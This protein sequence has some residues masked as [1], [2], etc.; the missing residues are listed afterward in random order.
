MNTVTLFFILSSLPIIYPII[1]LFKLKDLNLWDFLLFFSCIFFSLI[2]A[3]YSNLGKFAPGIVVNVSYIIFIFHS[4]LLLIDFNF[5]KKHDKEFRILNICYFLRHIHQLRLSIHGKFLVA[6]GLAVIIV[7]YLPRMSIAVRMGESASKT[8]Y[9]ISSVAMALNSILSIIGVILTLA[10]LSNL[11]RFKKDK[12]LIILVIVYLGIMIFMPRRIMVFSLIQFAVVYYALYRKKIS[13]KIIS[14]VLVLFFGIYF[15]YFPFYNVIRTNNVSFNPRHPIESLTAIINYGVNNFSNR[16][17]EA[18]QSTDE[19]TLGLYQALYNLFNNC[20]NW[21]NGSLTIAAIDGAIPRV[22]NPNKGNGTE[23]ILENMS[24]SYTDQADSILLEAC[25][26]F[27]S[28]GALYAVVLFLILFW[29]YEKYSYLYFKLFK[30]YLVPTFIMFEMLSITWNIEGNLGG[31]IAFFFSSIFTILLLLLLE[32]YKV[33]VITRHH[34]IKEA[35]V[36]KKSENISES[37]KND[38]STISLS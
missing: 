3:I 9:T 37:Q 38:E 18:S 30:S 29:L 25:G 22:F 32:R 27:S 19:R 21:G 33:V 5:R 14:Y 12:I 16:H 2:P 36:I 13:K 1:Q 23:Q 35:K 7:F 31:R 26:D 10:S 20:T 4:L 8:T 11:K 17:L 6:V 15:V 28:W 34:F 24:K